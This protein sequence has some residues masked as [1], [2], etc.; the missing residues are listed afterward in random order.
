MAYTTFTTSII[1]PTSG[2][3]A[4]IKDFHDALLAVGLTQTADTGQLDLSTAGPTRVGTTNFSY[5][6]TVYR[7]PSVSGLDD[8]FIRINHTNNADTSPVG[9]YLPRIT[10]G[11]GTDGAGAINANSTGEIVFTTTNVGTSSGTSTHYV[12]LTDGDLSIAFAP[13]EQLTGISQT[14]A[15]ARFRN[16]DGT[17]KNGYWFTSNSATLINS[18]R[19]YI[20]NPLRT[21]IATVIYN[22]SNTP[23]TRTDFP[24]IAPYLWFADSTLLNIGDDIPVFPPTILTPEATTALPVLWATNNVS[25]GN[26]FTTDRFGTSRT[27]I[28]VH[29]YPHNINF[30]FNIVLE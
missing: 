11:T 15:V 30:S 7:L 29:G 23:A 4:F 9:G 21:T 2:A 13:T 16:L 18:M 3:F 22:A 1:A 19:D 10:V 28:R 14:Y 17:K 12:A 25:V 27:F 8:I 26:T 24:I 5:G 6:Y 20:Y